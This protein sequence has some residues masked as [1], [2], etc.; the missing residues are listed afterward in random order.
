M[1]E[2]Y[3][4]IWLSVKAHDFQMELLGAQSFLGGTS[5][6]SWGGTEKWETEQ[7]GLGLSHLL[8]PEQLHGPA[9]TV[10][11]RAWVSLWP[12]I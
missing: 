12:I 1:L 2:D 3:V 11:E 5:G 8:Q 6:S 7:R 10:V 9:I 4:I